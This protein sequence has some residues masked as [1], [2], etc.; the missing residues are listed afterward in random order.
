MKKATLLIVFAVAIG[1][2][3]FAQLNME[4]LSQVQYDQDL[5]DVWGWAD[6]ETGIEYGIVGLRNGTSIV[7]LEDPENAVEVAYVPGPNTTWRDIKTWGHFAYVTNETSNGLLVIDMSNLPESVEYIEWT[8]T[9]DGLGTLSTCHNLYIDEFGFCYLAG[10][11]LNNGGMLILNVDTETGEPEFVSAGPAVYAHDVFVKSNLMYASEIYVGA[12]SIYDVE[13][14]QNLELLGQKNTPFNFTHNIW[15]NDAETVAFTTDE[16]A[17]A[18]VAAYDITDLDDIIELDLY[19]PIGSLGSGVIPHNVHVWDEYLLISYYT[20][21]GRVVDASRPENLIEVGNY[22]TWLGGDGGFSGA[23]GLY[24]FLPS[25][26]VLVSD[27]DNGLYVLQPNFVRACWLEGIVTD[28]VTENTISGVTVEIDSEQPNFAETDVFG[29]FQTGQAIS[30]TFEVTFKKPGYEDE[31]ISVDLNNGVLTFVEVEMSPLGMF[32]VSG[33]TIEAQGGSAVAGTE[34]QLLGEE[35]IYNV[36]AD[37]AGNF[38]L[39][40]VTEGTYDIL[41]GKWGY[42]HTVLEG[43]EIDG[44]T[45]V[46][47]E[48][49]EGYQDDFFA[50]LGWTS[51]A[52]GA[53]TGFWELGEPIGTMSGNGLE[54][55]PD[56]DVDGDIGNQCYITGNGGG[57]PGDDDVDDGIVTLTSP[58]MDL[59]NYIEPVLSYAYWFTNSSGNNPPNDQVVVR[60]TNGINEVEILNQNSSFPFWRT[61]ENIQIAGLLELTSNMQ[62]I[63]ETSDL[64]NSGNLVEAGFDAFLVS[65]EGTTSSVNDQHANIQ[66]GAFPNPFTNQA[67]LRFKLDEPYNEAEVTVYNAVG[68]LVERYPLNSDAGSI[69]LAGEL[70]SGLYLVNLHL[71]GQ[72]VRSLKIVKNK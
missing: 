70:E 17:D 47:I 27:I 2:C 45:S 24:P 7:S 49:E 53:T 42:L 32:A 59:S 9:I 4:L 64:P 68:Q 41:A 58:V 28:E 67:N 25:Q 23:W 66:F 55:N 46:T 35:L 34:V 30:G 22:D 18:P 40:A 29:E 20:D 26:T 65:E 8:P 19:N 38:S 6:P 33:E 57:G 63:V 71:D 14:K 37:A 69:M 3:S 54:S 62:I 15:T 39:A 13:D 50:D 1:Y 43:V 48:L 16:R 21:G 31:V 36:T 10:C 11:N 44:V 51:T 61:Q 60:L 72:I 12:M 52:D 56:M 5:N